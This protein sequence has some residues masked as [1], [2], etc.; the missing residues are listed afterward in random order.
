MVFEVKLKYHN[1]KK[2]GGLL[3]RLGSKQLLI[4][5]LLKIINLTKVFFE[6]NKV[7]IGGAIRI[8]STNIF[9]LKYFYK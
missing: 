2:N 1:T 4:I 7:V 3:V 5:I 6:N 9:E 8:L